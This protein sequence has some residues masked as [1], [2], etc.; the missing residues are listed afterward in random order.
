[1]A[2]AAEQLR[3]AREAAGLTIAQVA[4]LTKMRAD[5]VRAVEE[6]NYAVFGAPVYLRGF[7]R[8]YARLVHADEAAIF[9]ALDAELARSGH[10]GGPPA[11][12]GT[13][14]GALDRV[15]LRLSR[16]PWR[17]VLP[18][19]ALALVVVLATWWQLARERALARDP[20]DGVAP[21]RYELP[22]STGDTLPLPLPTP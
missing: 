22:D 3:T 19:L 21:G 8:S 14:E 18:V 17:W 12:S 1:M 4:E 7:V 13:H 10:W 20:L 5:R 6:G 16:V 15:M 9:A 2:T 11:L